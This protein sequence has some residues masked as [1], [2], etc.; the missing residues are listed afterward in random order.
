MT[1]QIIAGLILGL[2]IGSAPSA[3]RADETSGKV[4]DTG[5]GTFKIDEKGTTRQFNLSTSKSHYEPASWRPTI[6]DQVKVVFTPNQGSKGTVLAV[7][8]VALLKAGPNT[9]ASVESPVTGVVTEVGK[10]GIKAK[11]PS[12][13]IV[14]FSFRRG[15]ERIPAGW[16]P[17]AGEKARIESHPQPTMVFTVSFVLDKIEKVP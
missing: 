13:Q 12:G 1:K 11:L 3:V 15:M 17:V 8:Q 10:S 5:F 14:K 2:W 7:D 6:Q 16:V 4:T 9:L